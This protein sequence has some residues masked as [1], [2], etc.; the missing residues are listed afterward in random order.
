MSGNL[1]T[2]EVYEQMARDYETYVSSQSNHLT[3]RSGEQAFKE[4][5]PGTYD[6]F[7]KAQSVSDEER[8]AIFSGGAQP[9]DGRSVRVEDYDPEESA[10]QREAGNAA[11]ADLLSSDG[12]R[13]AANNPEEYAA[14]V[15]REQELER[16]AGG[17]GNVVQSALGGRGLYGQP[18]DPMAYGDPRRGGNVPEMAYNRTAPPP[19]SRPQ[20]RNTMLPQYGTDPYMPVGQG[21]PT[22]PYAPQA[23]PPQGHA[24]PMPPRQKPAQPPM[25]V[26]QHKPSGPSTPADVSMA[27]PRPSVQ[28]VEQAPVWQPLPTTAQ[29]DSQQAAPPPGGRTV[30]PQSPPPAQELQDPQKV[31]QQQALAQMAL[32]QQTTIP[33]PYRPRF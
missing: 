27:R 21:A 31:A 24:A 19:M 5:Y 3:R 6:A 2:R 14:A 13:Q 10:R 29:R 26:Y 25:N 8:E 11:N 20:G 22:S 12:S 7:Q 17:R 23:M 18:N 16:L 32:G 30:A 9:N 33:S 1:L 28:T 4:K 15:A